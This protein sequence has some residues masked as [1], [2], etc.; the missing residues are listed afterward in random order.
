MDKL[1]KARSRAKKLRTLLKRLNQSYYEKNDPEV[2][3]SKY[4]QLLRDLAVLENEFPSLKTEASP[5]QNVGGTPSG[6]FSVVAHA[7]PMLSLGN[8][9]GFEEVQAFL[10]RCKKGTGLGDIQWVTELKYDGLAVSLLYENGILSRGATR[11]DGRSGDDITENIRTL[12]EVPHQLASRG[13]KVQGLIEVRGEV[14]L[15]RKDFEAIN[16][17]REGQDEAPFVNPRNA[18]AG[19]LKMKDSKKVSK[20]PLRF[21]VYELVRAPSM[22]PWH[23]EGLKLCKQ[24]GFPIS[25]GFAVSHNDDS[26]WKFCQ[27]WEKDREKLK[28][29]ADGIVIKAD[30]L[31]LREI[32]GSTSKSPRWAMAYKFS[33]E[34]VSTKLLGI[35]IQVGRSGVMTPVADLEPVLLEGAT[36][37]KATLH[38]EDEIKRLGLR[39][40]DWVQIERSGGVIPK[41]LGPVLDRP[42][43]PKAY[44]MPRKCPSCLAPTLREA[45]ET[46]RRCLNLAC[47]AQLQRRIEHF[48]SKGGLDIEGLGPRHIEALIESGHLQGIVD[49]FSLDTET[50]AS[51]E[52]LGQKSAEKLVSAI[53]DSKSR[54]L[55]KLLFALGLRHVG[56]EAARSM[57]LEYR[58]MEKLARSSTEA[59]SEMDDIGPVIARSIIDFFGREQNL[60]EVKA[61]VRAGV[62]MESTERRARGGLLGMRL[63]FTGTLSSLGRKEAEARAKALGAKVSSTVSQK[64]SF[65]IL[66]NEPGS[67]AKR[68][69]KL[70]LKIISE[71]EFLALLESAKT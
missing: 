24:W 32:L 40:G 67:K 33:A 47:P 51:I 53:A 70:G 30:S 7:R 39:V 13:S 63:V 69:Q 46:A 42:R 41:I 23:S 68:A 16:A 45:D 10:E 8:A 38:N 3:D 55:G 64:T 57:A 12:D 31:D 19:S 60:S 27:R 61:L 9:F 29:D 20:R 44:R 54:G 28:F 52:G 36:I 17:V 6:D 48:V 18:A 21:V 49:I 56:I 5:T 65:L 35:R 25:H 1:A 26:V 71:K 2:A 62:S 37:K 34:K 66:G 22:P 43:G 4:D 59:L 50:M 14:Y 11:G 58:T 15:N